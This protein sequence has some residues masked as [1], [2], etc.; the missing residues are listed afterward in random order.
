MLTKISYFKIKI[1]LHIPT[2]KQ[3]NLTKIIA[4]NIVFTYESSQ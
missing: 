4:S 3:P 1:S 2:S